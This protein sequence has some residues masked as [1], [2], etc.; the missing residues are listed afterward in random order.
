MQS[1]LRRIYGLFLRQMYVIRFSAPRLAAYAFWPTFNIII[2]GFA[3][4]YIYTSAGVVNIAFSTLL[5][6][7]LIA[8]LFERTNIHV[9]WTFLEDVWARNL[10]NMMMSPLRTWEYITGLI[11]NS[12]VGVIFGFIIAAF[13]AYV[14]FDYSIFVMGMHF[15]LFAVNLMFFGWCIGVLLISLLLRFGQNA[16]HFGWMAVFAFS[17]FVAIYYPV[18]TLP[19]KAQYISWCLPPTYVFEGL[20]SFIKTGLFDWH[21]FEYSLLLNVVYFLLAGLM[22]IHQLQKARMRGGL[23]SMIQ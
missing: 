10:G 18:T 17:P 8:V 13:F 20:R 7:T 1:R 11:L 14:I 6:A 23:L 2:W 5:G 12:M 22:F 3:S 16:E 15:L 21:Y 4:K 19:E 9:M